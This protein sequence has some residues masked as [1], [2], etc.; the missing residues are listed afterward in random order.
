MALTPQQLQLQDRLFG[1]S[2]ILP[3]DAP[4]VFLSDG[5]VNVAKLRENLLRRKSEYARAGYANPAY[6]ASLAPGDRLRVE[7]QVAEVDALLNQYPEGAAGPSPFPDVQVI[8]PETGTFNP[9][10]AATSI[11]LDPAKLGF[12]IG[13]VL[14][15]SAAVAT[16]VAL[17]RRKTTKHKS[18][19]KPKFG[20]AAYRKKYGAKAKRNRKT[21]KKGVGTEGQF[22]RPGGKKVYYTKND[23]PYVLMANGKARFVKKR[24]R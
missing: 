23:Q 6:L 2:A 1:V 16:G 3:V 14:L 4:S 10:S 9:I 5:G 17:A 22:R 24:K 8:V 18:T 21:K 13:G 15:G 7:G 20:T 11:G 12:G 19:R